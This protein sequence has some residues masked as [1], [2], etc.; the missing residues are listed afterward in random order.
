MVI[1]GS[2]MNCFYHNDT[3]A[4]GICKACNKGI[5]IEC[6]TD[7]KHSL[8]CKNKCE[9]QAQLIEKIIQMS[10]EAVRSSMRTFFTVSLIFIVPGL[11]FLFFGL[12]TEP[13]FS[14]TNMLGLFMTTIGVAYI[15][16]MYRYRKRTK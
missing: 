11:I 7:L 2:E 10:G 6:A 16:F 5:C 3:S 12:Q 8:A 15:I 1:R 13:I 14:I 4:V 9:K